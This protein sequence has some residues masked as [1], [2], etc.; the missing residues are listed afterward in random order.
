MTST[1]DVEAWHRAVDSRDQRFDGRV[2]LGVTSTGIYCRPSC[3]ARRPKRENRQFYR[4]PAA[5]V[6]A[7]FRACRLCRPDAVP[8]S[9]EWD[10]GSALAARA[11]RLIAA[12][13]VD[14]HGVGGLARSLAV[15]ERHLHRTLVA[16]VG[17]GPLSLAR[18]RRAQTARLLIDQTGLSMADVAFASGFASLRQ[19]ND[20]MR[21]EFGVPPSQLRR[22]PDPEAAERAPGGGLV[23]RLTHREPFAAG[24][25]FGFLV[26]R[27]IP[28]LESADAA[29]LRRVVSTPGGPAVVAVEP[30]PGAGHVRAQ[31][32]LPRLS[33]LAG[34]VAGVRRLLDLDA[35]PDAVDAVLSAE[36][37]L[38]RLVAARPGLRVSGAV[39]GFELAVRAVLG[40]QVSVGGARTLAGRLVAAFGEP[41]PRS[42]GAL[43]TAFPTAEVLATADLGAIGLTGARQRALRELS[44][45]VAS[46]ALRL[47]PGADRT[48][49]R[50]RLLAVPGVG[51]WTAE[52]VALRARADP[53]AWPGTDLVL[54]RQAQ[55]YGVRPDRLRPWRSYAAQ[56]LWSDAAAPVTP[57][58]PVTEENR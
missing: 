9:R 20:V 23:L 28:G 36:P 17:A 2:F 25:L 21:T 32:R 34:V 50:A 48:E 35:E 49:T 15:S 44:A 1:W 46:G 53:D 47:D 30:V 22:R 16:E 39:D 41:L 37:G 12:G 40:Q 54:R 57:V 45:A 18:T 8:G 29:E 58:T 4:T 52:Y 38:A 7:G 5:A 10:H 6:A 19:F 24:P 43:T 13:A 51:P 42:E 3:P 33:D 26:A 14:E 55:R 56:H 31:V 27:A 11:L